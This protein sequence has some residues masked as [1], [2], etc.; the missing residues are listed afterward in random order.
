[1]SYNCLARIDPE[2]RN[3]WIDKANDSWK[4]YTQNRY[5][6]IEYVRTVCENMKKLLKEDKQKGDAY[7]NF[8]LYKFENKELKDILKKVK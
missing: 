6:E 2:N 8:N 1:M 7:Y 4:G 5:N 3:K